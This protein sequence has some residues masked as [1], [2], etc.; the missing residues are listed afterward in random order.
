MLPHF[1]V[2]RNVFGRGDKFVSRCVLVYSPSG[3]PNSKLDFFRGVR[4]GDTFN[5]EEFS[6]IL[7]EEQADLDIFTYRVSSGARFSEL[8]FF[9][10]GR[11]LSNLRGAFQCGFC[12]YRMGQFRAFPFQEIFT[13][14]RSISLRYPPYRRPISLPQILQGRERRL[15][16]LRS[17]RLLCGRVL[18]STTNLYFLH[19]TCRMLL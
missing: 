10:W 16:R 7:V 2:L 13:V 6:F 1:R 17:V 15:E 8:L 14:S 4:E 5:V 19:K 12:A 18:R 3:C 9:F 11:R